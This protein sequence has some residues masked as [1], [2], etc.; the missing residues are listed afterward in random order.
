MTDWFEEYESLPVI[1]KSKIKWTYT[2]DFEVQ[3]KYIVA[4][5]RSTYEKLESM[6]DEALL[7]TSQECYNLISWSV[8]MKVMGFSG[9]QHYLDELLVRE[10][11]NKD[12]I[13]NL[14]YKTFNIWLRDKEGFYKIGDNY[15]VVADN[16]VYYR[17]LDGSW[18][19]VEK[20]SAF[21]IYPGF[22]KA[23]VGTLVRK[24]NSISQTSPYET[25]YQEWM[26]D[27]YANNTP[28]NHYDVV[29]GTTNPDK[30]LEITL[31]KIRKIIDQPVS[32][33]SVL[34]RGKIDIDSL[35]Q[36]IKLSFIMVR[37]TQARRR[38]DEHTVYLLRDC[39]MFDEIHKTLDILD[40]KTTS[41]DRLIVCRDLLTNKKRRGGHWYFVQEALFF[42][43]E[44]HPKDFAAFFKEFSKILKDYEDYSEEFSNYLKSLSIYI[45]E[46]IKQS[47]SKLNINFVDL[48]FQGSINILLKYVVEN[49]SKAPHKR[50]VN[51]HMTIVADWFKDIYKGMYYSDTYS[52]LTVIESLGRNEL[53]YRYVL[54]SFE[55]GDIAV[56]MGTKA[57][58]DIS[59]TELLVSTMVTLISSKLKLV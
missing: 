26:K 47:D 9:L 57:E 54:G 51:I 29:K 35:E 7:D 41:S 13:T 32:I 40:Q 59:N 34:L 18:W 53:M 56:N 11:N 6:N 39:I 33:H 43:C 21:N 2:K 19:L 30:V 42:A 20:S 1:E 37:F 24:L 27:E 15:F 31:T 8:Q 23:V 36:L 10:F 12:E 3:S 48:G 22:H 16:Q 58:Q 25:I 45:D 50:H 17:K 14:Q 49:H 55:K 5:I 52:L 38:T 46:H 28:S 44:K 4:Y